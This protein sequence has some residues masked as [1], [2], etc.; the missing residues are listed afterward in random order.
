M[1]SVPECGPALVAPSSQPGA[2]KAA[3]NSRLSK[4]SPNVLGRSNRLLVSD[5]F[6]TVLRRGRKYSITG[7]L[8]A[9]IKATPGEARWGF[10]VPKKVGSAV[11]R[12]RVKRRL[13]EAAKSLMPVVDG[14]DIV[15]RAN[16]DAATVSVE[17]WVTELSR[18]LRSDS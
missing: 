16:G 2:G 5:E 17:Q 7:G 18:A 1:V 11:V 10:I 3:K 6:R 4:W 14:V 12:N 8:V 9:V 15:V 13:R